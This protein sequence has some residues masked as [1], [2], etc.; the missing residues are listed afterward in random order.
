MSRKY[1]TLVIKEPGQSWSPQFGDW[2][3][4]CVEQELDDVRSD[5]PRGTKFKI[6]CTGGSQAHINDAIDQLNHA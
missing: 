5:W 3:K 2:Y 6:I 1:F 4:E